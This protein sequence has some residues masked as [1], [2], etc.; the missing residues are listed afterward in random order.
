MSKGNKIIVNAS[1]R[2]VFEWG[3]M[4]DTSKPGTLMQ[5]DSS[6]TVQGGRFG[7]KAS[8]L[9]TDGKTVLGGVLLE[10]SL[11]GFDVTTAYVSATLASMYY[12]LRGEDMNILAGE[13]AGT[14]NSYTIGDS[15]I[16]DAE[17]GI[18]VP[19]SGSPEQ[20]FAM[21]RETVSQQAG[22]YLLWVVVV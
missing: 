13:V 18:L 10:D 7:I 17:N 22:N 19:F 4:N 3:V 2:G 20:T 9:G 5:L 12:P 14:G 21:S 16:A 11:Q 6:V 8:N 1:P 15:L